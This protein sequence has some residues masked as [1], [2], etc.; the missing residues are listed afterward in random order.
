MLDGDPGV[1]GA[2]L[3]AILHHGD[4]RETLA[5][6]EGAADLVLTSPPYCDARTYGA[7]VS[8]GMDDYA[9]LGDACF[10]ALRPG[11]GGQHHNNGSVN[12]RTHDVKGGARA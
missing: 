5:L 3:S 4:F 2:R 12:A 10:A 1:A 11:G 9:A 8:W 7:A 6:C